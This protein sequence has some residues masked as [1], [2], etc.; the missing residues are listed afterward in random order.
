MKK[1]GTLFRMLLLRS[2]RRKL[3]LSFLFL[4]VLPISLSGLISFQ[5]LQE[6]V[7]DKMNIG[8]EM[9]ISQAKMNIEL[10]FKNMVAASNSLLMDS[11][12]QDI[13][14]QRSHDD[15]EVLYRNSR[16][17]RS[18]YFAV[19]TSALD[20]YPNHFITLLNAE[21]FSFSTI[22][23]EENDEFQSFMRSLLD[24]ERVVRNDNYIKLGEYTHNINFLPYGQLV[25]F[26]ILTRAYMDFIG[27][28]KSGDIIVGIPESALSDI[29]NGIVVR[30]SIR[31]Y[32][33][34]ER[35]EILSST[36]KA[37][38]GTVLP[39]FAEI[40]KA[41]PTDTIEAL[42]FDVIA[43]VSHME[44]LGWTVVGEVPDKLLYAEIAAVRQW[45]VY[46]NLGFIAAFLTLAF[47]IANGIS[48][49][50][51]KLKRATYEFA[52][53]RLDSRVE[54][55]GVDELAMLALKFN[56]MTE[57]IG[58]LVQQVNEDEKAKRELEIQMLYSQINPHF[59]FNTLNSIRW[60]AEASKV[61]NVSKL[62]ASLA[63]LLR[64]S[65]VQKN[66]II[67]IAEELDN[68][69]HYVTIQKMR[70]AALFV[71]EYEI[72]DEV[73]QYGIPKLILQPIVENS[74]LHGF[75]DISYKGRIHIRAY[76]HY[77]NVE[78]VIT[79]NGVG[80]DE[81]KLASLLRDKSASSNGFSSI[82]ISNVNERLKL[83]FGADYALQMNNVAGGGT[84]TKVKLPIL[85]LQPTTL[86]MELLKDD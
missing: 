84:S 47:W 37:D 32:V 9:A 28:G 85:S 73:L 41:G 48:K 8:N 10:L 26:V 70:F 69:R 63:Q 24:K 4:I 67:P 50:I 83:H 55:S 27:G 79:D 29:L 30:E 66:E 82:G 33:I 77:D 34:N 61:Y 1:L 38:I 51:G 76:R 5:F 44:R 81:S 7:K 3:V 25:P 36:N 11:E 43:N 75:A 78:I 21:G 20:N 19:Q 45:L 12:I 49:P 74:I 80:C 13:M 23:M 71:D 68:I 17:M 22:P 35:G 6:A 52:T 39:Y 59:L 62:I 31:G 54:V 14:K 60:M 86:G 72:E 40:Q 57:E 64:S 18:K 58:N 15:R 2:I 53:G 46:V 42:K 65:I 56:K 16:L